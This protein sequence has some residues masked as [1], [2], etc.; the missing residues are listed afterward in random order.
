[1]C[2]LSN[3]RTRPLIFTVISFSHSFL[4]IIPVCQKLNPTESLLC[5]RHKIDPLIKI[6]RH[7]PWFLPVPT[8]LQSRSMVVQ[9]RRLSAPTRT[10]L[11]SGLQKS[12]SLNHWQEQ[13][14]PIVLLS[15]IG[16]KRHSLFYLKKHIFIIMRQAHTMLCLI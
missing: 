12:T 16:N 2:D 7:R 11:N 9:P 14:V 1:M 10:G 4:F 15:I 5:P 8:R 3:Y 6:P 13:S